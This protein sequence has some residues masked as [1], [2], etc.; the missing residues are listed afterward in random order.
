MIVKKV[1]GECLT[2]MG[3][4]DFTDNTTYSESEQGLIDSLLAALNIAYR[5]VIC[6]YLPL[7]HSE[8]VT[9]SDG[10]LYINALEKKILYP[11]RVTHGDNV[12]SFKA[13]ADRITTKIS[14][15]ATLEYAYLPE[16]E[17]TMTSVIS[18]LRLTDGALSDGT[19]GEYY[20]ANKVF[21]LAK[22][23]DSSFREKM[24]FLRYKGRR[25][26]LKERRWQA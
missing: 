20:F 3:E 21:D 13:Y 14:G 5:E 9:F 4:R 8:A 15:T 23:Y 12:V 18:D 19:L 24:G 2:K 10:V 25:L 17:L 7:V 11:I 16:G 22:S 1:I 26:R 6:E